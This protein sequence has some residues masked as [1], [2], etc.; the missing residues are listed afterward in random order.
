MKTPVTYV[1]V[2]RNDYVILRIAGHPKNKRELLLAVRGNKVPYGRVRSVGGKMLWS[3][4]RV[5]KEF[6]RV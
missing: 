5:R 2:P 3:K 6:V 1:V 4:A